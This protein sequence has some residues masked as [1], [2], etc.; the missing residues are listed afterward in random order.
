MGVLGALVLALGLGLGALFPARAADPLD[1]RATDWRMTDWQALPFQ[2]QRWVVVGFAL[3]WAGAEADAD[4]PLPDT[5]A[6]HL[7]LAEIAAWATHEPAERRVAVALTLG[8]RARPLPAYAVTGGTWIALES[9]HRLAL[10]HGV[11]AG[12]YGA[13][14]EAL[15]E[16]KGGP[17]KLDAAFAKARR[18]V[19]PE[20]ALAPSLL[21]ARLSDWLFYTDRRAAPLVHSI[22]E[23]AGQIRGQ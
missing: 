5:D 8:R 7:R 1:G 14:L 19:K 6:L 13:A 12:A 3:G 11:Y 15:P 20:L 16:A 21:F 18:L 2:E 17:E 22:R 4:G 10:L 9:R 23:I